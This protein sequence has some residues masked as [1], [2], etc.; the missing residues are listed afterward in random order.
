LGANWIDAICVAKVEESGKLGQIGGAT[1]G[2][3][4]TGSR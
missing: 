4:L 3:D 2:L 1:G